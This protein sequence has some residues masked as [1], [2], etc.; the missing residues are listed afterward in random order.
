MGARVLS[1][2]DF[3]PLD[4]RRGR[5]MCVIVSASMAARFWP[6]TQSDRGEQLIV[7][8]QRTWGKS[9][10]EPRWQTVVAWSTTSAIEA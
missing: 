9:F 10:D 8:G 6:G 5:S 3:T 4:R 1:G 2:R 7:P